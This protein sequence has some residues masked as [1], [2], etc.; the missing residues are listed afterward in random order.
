MNE[1]I[2]EL[3]STSTIAIALFGIA[4]CLMQNAYRRVN[5]SFAAFLGVVALNNIPDAF[6]RMVDMTQPGLLQGV[7]FAIWLCTALCLSPS[8][9]VYVFT[10]TSRAQRDPKHLYRHLVLPALGAIVGI[11]WIFGPGDAI[12]V[13][14]SDDDVS[15]SGWSLVLATWIGLLQL[16]IYVQ[17]AVYLTL[18]IRRLL[19]YKRRLRDIYASTEEH[20]LR[21]IYVIGALGLLFWVAQS[22]FLAV[23]ID[24]AWTAIPTAILSLVGLVLF[25]ATTLWGLRQRPP[26]VPDTT[27]EKPV[28][29]SDDDQTKPEGRK[30]GKSALSPE[31]SA[32]LARKIRAA[33]EVDHLHKDPNLSLW[34]LA[35]HIGASPNYISQT[36]NDVIGESFFDFVNRHRVLEAMKLLST[37][38]DT[39]SAI[40]YDV[41]FNARSSFYNA[42]K[43]VTGQTPTGYRKSL[44]VREGM[45]DAGGE[46][47]E[48]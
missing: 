8:L 24:P 19:Q 34:A 3:I 35:R 5:R 26:L 4:F 7:V 27:D 14:L 25:A 36:L 48:T 18:I 1:I 37:T 21:W 23:A 29:N 40:T 47:R 32:R 13:L 22:L 45:V 17:L 6:G 44:S 11:L 16:A 39:V 46:L 28:E 31:A 33:M 2:L 9:W 10:L 43:R 20:E 41:G 15:L 38:D 12:A 42:F 30:Y